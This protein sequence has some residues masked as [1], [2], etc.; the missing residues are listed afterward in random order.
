MSLRSA[1][2]KEIEAKNK[3]LQKK[4]D[5]ALSRYIETSVADGR[6]LFVTI[7]FKQALKRT[8]GTFE[9]LTQEAADNETSFF[10]RKIHQ[11]VF[12]KAYTRFGKSLQWIETTEGGRESGKRIHR[13]FL[14]EIP[15]RFTTSAFEQILEGVWKRSRWSYEQIDIQTA[16]DPKTVARYITK[17]GT[18]S[19]VLRNLTLQ[20]THAVV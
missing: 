2:W 6:F 13:H 10:K 19:V 18:E 20:S 17:T 11:T 8:D 14:I 12:G 7:T 4:A 5:S 9:K 3:Q 16:R 15:H 1:Q